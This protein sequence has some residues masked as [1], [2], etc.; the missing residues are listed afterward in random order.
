MA[1][2]GLIIGWLGIGYLV[3]AVLAI[4]ALFFIGSTTSN[5]YSSLAALAG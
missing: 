4:F 2:A 1:Q 3:L 5:D